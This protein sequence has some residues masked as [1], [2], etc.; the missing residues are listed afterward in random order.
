[1]KQCVIDQGCRFQPLWMRDSTSATVHKLRSTLRLLSLFARCL[2]D[3][4]LVALDF[5]PEQASKETRLCSIPTHRADKAQHP[6]HGGLV[7]F[8]PMRPGHYRMYSSV[9]DSMWCC[10]GSGIEN[11]SKYG[12]PLTTFICIAKAITT[13]NSV[14]LQ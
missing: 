9:Q 2:P 10:V 12:E 1:M 5:Q 13:N 4:D 14:C 7:Y 6:E 3:R 11:H 8:T